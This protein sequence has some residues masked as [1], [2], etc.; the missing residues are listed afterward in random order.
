[1]NYENVARAGALAML[2]SVFILGACTSTT[3]KKS[4]CPIAGT[5]TVTGEATSDDCSSQSTN[6]SGASSTTYTITA[7]DSGDSTADFAIEIQGLAGGCV[8]DQINTCKVQGKC[9]LRIKDPVSPANDTGTFQ[10]SWTF[11]ASGFKGTYALNAPPAKS[12][13]KGCTENGTSKGACQ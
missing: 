9:D 11:D 2:G 4:S 5:Y 6:E 7:L 1:M 8:D 12:L 3:D 13:P 10:F